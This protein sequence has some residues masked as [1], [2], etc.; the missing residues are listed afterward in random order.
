MNDTYSAQLD[1]YLYNTMTLAC[2]DLL[3]MNQ[4]LLISLGIAQ[5]ARKAAFRIS[6]PA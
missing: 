4:S 1:P 3:S 6:R 2:P 5:T